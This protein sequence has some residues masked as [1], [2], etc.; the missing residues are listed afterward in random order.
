MAFALTLEKQPAANDYWEEFSKRLK[1]T[2]FNA[3]TIALDFHATASANDNAP[4]LRTKLKNLS[5]SK[6]FT[7]DT[8]KSA[9]S[10]IAIAGVSKLLLT[11]ALHTIGFGQLAFLSGAA[12]SLGMSARQN[13]DKKQSLKSNLTK[14]FINYSTWKKAATS[15]AL[16]SVGAFGLEESISTVADAAVVEPIINIQNGV[17]SVS[18]DTQADTFINIDPLKVDAK[19]QEIILAQA[20]TGLLAP[21]EAMPP[22]NTSVPTAKITLDEARQAQA[23]ALIQE[24]NDA[25]PTPSGNTENIYVP[26]AKLPINVDGVLSDE[27]LLPPA[28]ITPPSEQDVGPVNTIEETNEPLTPTETATHNNIPEIEIRGNDTEVEN[29]PINNGEVV[30]LASLAAEQDSAQN[31]PTSEPEP[32]KPQTELAQTFASEAEKL[33]TLNDSYTIK[34]GDTLYDIVDNLYEGEDTY[35]REAMA[36]SIAR[37][38]G[39]EDIGIIDV[40]DT[41]ILP[42]FFGQHGFYSLTTDVSGGNPVPGVSLRP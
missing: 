25:L 31:V 11:T 3:K 16:A 33:A 17:A 19:A 20:D 40:G 32:E 42:E 6:L 15:A 35:N 18:T 1:E 13:W 8:L 2:S 23:N 7:R 34:S 29:T 38:N 14:T 28:Q 36:R 41:L 39:I 10:G 22:S 21:E 37:I 30:S 12:V 4:D 5:P 24:M 9:A 26:V 27:A